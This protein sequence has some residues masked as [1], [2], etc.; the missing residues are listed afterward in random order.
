MSTRT[1][2]VGIRKPAFQMRTKTAPVS[3]VP[4]RIDEAE[5]GDLFGSGGSPT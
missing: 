4:R 5:C 2:A 3:T 1:D